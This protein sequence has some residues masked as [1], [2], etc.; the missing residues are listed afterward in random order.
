MKNDEISVLGNQK[1]NIT[2]SIMND[3]QKEKNL[4]H[5]RS[6]FSHISKN[7]ICYF[8]EYNEYLLKLSKKYTTHFIENQNAA[9][10]LPTI[11]DGLEQKSGFVSVV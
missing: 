3:H 10:A 4:F 11:L 7:R 6:R 1:L 2:H 9:N 5:E 8:N